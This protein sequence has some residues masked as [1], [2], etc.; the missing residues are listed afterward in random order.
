MAVLRKVDESRRREVFIDGHQGSDHGYYE[1][2]VHIDR[3]DDFH[4]VHQLVVTNVSFRTTSFSLPS[5]R[6]AT[7]IASL[8]LERFD[9]FTSDDGYHRQCCHRVRPPPAPKCIE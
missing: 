9:S 3:I 2:L 1:C 7:T 5:M 8:P 4:H 6:S